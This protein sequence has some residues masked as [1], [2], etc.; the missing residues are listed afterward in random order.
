MSSSGYNSDSSDY[1]NYKGLELPTRSEEQSSDGYRQSRRKERN[2]K[3]INE[4]RTARQA[5]EAIRKNGDRLYSLIGANG[6]LIE[7]LGAIFP[8]KKVAMAAADALV[9][10]SSY[11]RVYVI[12]QVLSTFLPYEYS[13]GHFS[14]DAGSVWC[15]DRYATTKMD[16]S[17]NAITI[18]KEREED[19]RRREEEDAKTTAA[20]KKYRAASEAKAKTEEEG[21][22][23][24]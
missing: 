24:L 14:N 21:G 9:L 5:K 22:R 3:K 2:D 15:C 16:R 20:M 11:H 17:F 18:I 7:P 8:A 6:Y 13:S 1:R 10:S 12:Q 19:I 4:Q 23:N